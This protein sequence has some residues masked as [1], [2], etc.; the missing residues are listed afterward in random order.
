MKKLI[1]AGLMAL[2]LSCAF[3]FSYGAPKLECRGKIKNNIIIHGIGGS[4]I[5]FGAMDIALDKNMACSKSHYFEYD[6]KN[7]SLT[8]L[9]FAKKLN[10]L[11]DSIPVNKNKKDLNF[12]MHSQ[13]GLVG[14][15]F[16]LNEFKKTPGFNPKHL[17]RMNKFVS[18]STPFWGSDFAM[19][20]NKVFF[21]LGFSENEISPFGK[22]QLVDMEYGSRFL[23]NQLKEVFAKENKDFI[24]YLKNELKILN[25]SGMAPYSS[26]ILKSFG[27][28]FLE[29]DLIVNIPSMTLNTLKA[30]DNTIDYKE[31][32]AKTLETK[33]SHIAKQAYVVGT[34]MDVFFGTIGYGVVD[35]PE[36]CLNIRN[37][38]HPGFNILYT[39]LTKDEVMTDRDI[40]KTI[41]GFDLHLQVQFPK[42]QINLEDSYVSFPDNNKPNI[43]IGHYRM[44]MENFEPIT[45]NTDDSSAYYLIK[46]NL[47]GEKKS[48]KVELEI[49]HTGIE[50]RTVIVEVEKGKATFINLKMKKK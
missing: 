7:S 37:C 13:G 41:K 40:D 14:L 45:I 22:D 9:D 47:W 43:D 39:F 49:H 16:L 19:M 27:S 2:P 18:M 1:T 46:G 26:T 6:T 11:L 48:S 5:S 50:S 17:Q 21:N 12:I 28:Q 8:N 34:H 20:G 36:N 35:V 24:N 3:G 15:T 30:Q 31:G 25:I 4:Q 42:G 10:K 44:N 38:E 32:V 33:R 23:R 29:G